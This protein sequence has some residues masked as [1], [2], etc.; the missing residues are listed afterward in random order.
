MKV[1]YFFESSH[2][3]L[4]D[5]INLSLDKAKSSLNTETKDRSQ[6]SQ[7]LL[8]S[9]TKFIENL[10]RFKDWVD[11]SI[12]LRKPTFFEK[13]HLALINFSAI[14]R[15]IFNGELLRA[16]INHY[17]FIVDNLTDKETILEKSVGQLKSSVCTE[18]FKPSNKS[19]S[20]I[21]SAND[22]NF[23]E[24]PRRTRQPRSFII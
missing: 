19:S 8:E 18:F 6:S 23:S 5:Q 14:Q 11:E 24:S 17:K 1:S 21:G 20:Q 9:T 2:F 4:V 16:R 12:L 15:S 13:L 22:E 10:N 7:I 3:F